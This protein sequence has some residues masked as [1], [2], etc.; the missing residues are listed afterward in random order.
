MSPRIEKQSHSC[1]RNMASGAKKRNDAKLATA[2]GNLVF[3]GG[4]AWGLLGVRIWH[5]DVYRLSSRRRTNV[6]FDK[7]TFQGDQW[8]VSYPILLSRISFVQH[9]DASLIKSSRWFSTTLIAGFLNV[10]TIDML[11][12]VIF[13]LCGL[14]C[15]LWDFKEHFWSLL[16][17][18]QWH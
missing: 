9:H 6:L 15:A 7:L 16:T 12:K 3:G 14:S 11:D 13:L 8:R 10:G 1:Q 4:C 2:P 18:C 17:G 5:Q